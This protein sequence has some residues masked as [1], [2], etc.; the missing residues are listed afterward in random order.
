MENSF[1]AELKKTA[2]RKPKVEGFVW[3]TMLV[4]YD[5][6]G[7]A[8]IIRSFTK[9]AKESYIKSK[10]KPKKPITPKLEIE[11]TDRGESLF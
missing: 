11:T 4:K 2:P 1:L 8:E 5:L 10:I 7:H 9:P 3:V 6:D